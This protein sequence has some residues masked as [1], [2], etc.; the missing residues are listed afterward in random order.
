MEKIKIFIDDVEYISETVIK[1]YIIMLLATT[2]LD[3]SLSNN[4]AV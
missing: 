4:L 3:L 1:L 2:N